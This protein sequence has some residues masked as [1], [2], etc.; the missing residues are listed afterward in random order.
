M[1]EFNCTCER[2]H[3]R[4]P[5]EGYDISSGA[6]ENIP[7]VLKDYRRIYLVADRNTYRAAG[8]RVE[9]ILKANG[10]HHATHVIDRDVVL[11]NAETL[12]EIVFYANDHAAIS[13]IFSY[14]PLPD[15]ILAVGSGTINDSCRL[16]SYR[17]GLPYAGSA[18]PP[19]WTA[20]PPPA[21]PSCT[22]AQNRPFRRPR[23]DISSAILTS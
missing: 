19:Q 16:A 11:P 15:L 21:P 23:R 5:L 8:A 14:S 22:T 20:M 6:I 12:G 10:M 17:L 18:P 1:F 13:D 3:H 2:K 7:E 9:S 4:A